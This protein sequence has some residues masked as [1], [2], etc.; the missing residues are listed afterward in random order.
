LS[1]LLQPLL[2]PAVVR[3]LWRPTVVCAVATLE[4]RCQCREPRGTRAHRHADPKSLAAY[5]DHPEG[6][7]R[8]LPR[9]ADGLVRKTRGRLRLWLCAEPALAEKDR[10]GNAPGQERT[11][12]HRETCTCVL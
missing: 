1:R 10:Q 7:L 3:F 6:R 4:Y 8:V 5:P 2:L 12:A 9:R 11:A